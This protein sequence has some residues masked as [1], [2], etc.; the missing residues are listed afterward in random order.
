MERDR[1][2]W[3]EMGKNGKSWDLM[4]RDGRGRT[5]AGWVKSDGSGWKETVKKDR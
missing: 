3:R 5:E 2:R 4:E 1:S